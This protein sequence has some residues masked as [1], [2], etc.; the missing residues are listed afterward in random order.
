MDDISVLQ[1]TDPRWSDFVAGQPGATAFH[2]PDWTRVVAGCYGFR[3]FALAATDA[4]GAIRAGLPV[5][6]GAPP[7]WRP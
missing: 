7:P 3:A 5:V 4:T 6:E 2:H 1:L